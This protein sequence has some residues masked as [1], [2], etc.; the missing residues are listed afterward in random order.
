MPNG[1][2]VE[3]WTLRTEIQT[4]LQQAVDA[5]N[6]RNIEEFMSFYLVSEFTTLVTS[7]E[8]IFGY[9]NIREFYAKRGFGEGFLSICVNDVLSI[10]DDYAYA[11]AQSLT[12]V[13]GREIHQN[14]SFLM[15]RARTLKKYE[16]FVFKDHSA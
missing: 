14:H 2:P 1:K 15:Q 16:W 5:W 12:Q 4:R 11:I 10:G 7:E 9:Q 3:S 13:D 8:M 6:T